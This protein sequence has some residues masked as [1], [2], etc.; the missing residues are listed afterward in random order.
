VVTSALRMSATPPVV[1]DAAPRLGQ[2]TAEILGGSLGFSEEQVAHLISDGV[3]E[4][5]PAAG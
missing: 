5:R 1:G 2:H 4:Y 3:V